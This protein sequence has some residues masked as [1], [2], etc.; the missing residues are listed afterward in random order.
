MY[1]RV[2][3]WRT[4]L[5]SDWRRVGEVGDWLLMD[6]GGRP[7]VVSFECEKLGWVEV[8]GFREIEVV[9]GSSQVLSSLL[10]EEKKCQGNQ[11]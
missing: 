7:C 3:T 6:A 11:Y 2:N 8:E 4:E 5:A 10:G 1:V 9:V